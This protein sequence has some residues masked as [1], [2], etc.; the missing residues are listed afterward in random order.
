MCLW[1]DCSHMK[2]KVEATNA[3]GNMQL[4]AGHQSGIKANL[5]VVWAIWPQSAGWIKDSAA[6]EE[7]DGDPPSTATLQNHVCAKGVLAPGVDPGA[8]EDAS[9]SCYKPGL[10]LALLS[11]MPATASKRSTAHH[12]VEC[13][14]PMESRE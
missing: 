13:G 8:A 2:T 7:E 1:S 11:L 14:P 10:A 3:C 9:F 5:H 6:E 12:A 4:C